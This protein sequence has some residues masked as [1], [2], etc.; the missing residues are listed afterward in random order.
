M[1]IA[2]LKETAE[3]L[4]QT[5]PEDTEEMSLICAELHTARDLEDEISKQEQAACAALEQQLAALREPFRVQK[6]AAQAVI[7]AATGALVR[8]LEQDELDALAAIDAGRSVPAPVQLPKGLRMT[9]KTTLAA[10]DMALLPS[11]YHM[12][13]ADQS[14]ILTAAE[15]GLEIDGVEIDIKIGCVYTRAKK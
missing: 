3:A 6:A 12:T 14:K 2:E 10:V 1:N 15:A 13:V 4:A 11:E 5:T 8:K 7:A 9:R